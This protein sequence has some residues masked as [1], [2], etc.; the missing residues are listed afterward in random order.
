MSLKGIK[1]VT[2]DVT[3]TLLK[4]RMPA[5]QYYT[6][7]ARDHGFTGNEAIVEGRFKESYKVML[8]KYP[9]FGRSKITW[10]EWW[11][12]VIKKTF[13]GQLPAT[14]NIYTIA[15]KLINEFR[16]A[17]CW[18]VEPTGDRLLCDLRRQCKTLGVISNFD[19]RL[20]EILRN[21]KLQSYFDFVLASYQVGYSKPDKRIFD[22]AIEQCKY[23]VKPS[24]A[25]H[26]GDDLH[27]DYEGAKSAG[28]HAILISNSHK[29]K[30]SPESKHVFKNLEELS[31]KISENN[32][33]L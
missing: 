30:E 29:P 1:L 22:H 5:W 28:W 7:I 4:F 6:L 15:N 20:N 14:A 33:Q 3:N 26:I 2:F 13:E 11:T 16:T 18:R 10:E 32:I 8:N 25:L 24:E 17:K 31:L 21:V 12:E 27:K 19:P 9:N 23:L